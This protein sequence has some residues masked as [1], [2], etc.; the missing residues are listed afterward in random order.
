MLIKCVICLWC[1]E[2]HR[3]MKAYELAQQLGVSSH[4]VSR[5][6]GSMFLLKGN[7]SL[8]IGLNLKN[9]KKNE[10]VMTETGIHYIA[11]R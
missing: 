6:T 3:Y 4:F 7:E 8:H 11:R 9:N 2:S 1:Q 10:E 5:I